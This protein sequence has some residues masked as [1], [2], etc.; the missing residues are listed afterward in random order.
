MSFEKFK[1]DLIS[2]KWTDSK[3]STEAVQSAKTVDELVSAVACDSVTPECLLPLIRVSLGWDDA[4][5]TAIQLYQCIL[6][7]DSI[8]DC[9]Y[10]NPSTGVLQAIDEHGEVTRNWKINLTF[11]EVSNESEVSGV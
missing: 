3:F 8:V 9:M 10:W 2:R 1:R 7:D 11:E 4:G 6:V 5:D